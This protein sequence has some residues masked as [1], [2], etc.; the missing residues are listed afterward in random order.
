MYKCYFKNKIWK[1][2]YNE[3]LKCIFKCGYLILILH[4]LYIT[5]FLL[6][7]EVHWSYTSLIY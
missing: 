2:H 6:F 3:T 5:Y 7:L 4:F 1:V